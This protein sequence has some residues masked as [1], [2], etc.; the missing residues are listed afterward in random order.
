MWG[1]QDATEHPERFVSCGLW[2]LL[3]YQPG[4]RLVYGRNPHFWMVDRLG[5]R[6]PYLH[7]YVVT[8]AKDL[9]NLALQ[10]EQGRVESYGVP[11]SNLRHVRHLQRPAFNL[12]NLG[13]TSTT[14]FLAFNLTQA[15]TA[16]KPRVSPVR[17]AWFRS[18]R[19]RQAVAYAIRRDVLVQNVLRGVGE[20]LFTAEG[21]PSLYLHPR[22]AQG[23]AHNLA[24]AR[25]LLREDGFGWDARGRLLD[26]HGNPVVFDMFTN[27]GNDQREATGVSL[28]Q[29]L[30]ELGIAVHFKP[31]DFNV[32]V[33][34]LSSGQWETMVMGLTGSALEP[35]DGANVWKSQGALHLFNQ[36]DVKALAGKTPTDRLPWEQELDAVFEAGAQTLL[37]EKR[38]PYYLRYQEIVAEQ[39]P[40][41]YLFSPLS[42]VAIRSHLRN[43]APTTLGVWHNLE[44]VWIAPET[45]PAARR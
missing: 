23:Y 2:V 14:T 13:P 25:A 32:L 11:G 28:Q 20:A 19:F 5:R 44:E 38:R 42:V 30:A 21:L 12:Y 16:G 8:F 33:G 1:V 36:R 39:N 9:N 37:P 4:E 3:S 22:L 34:K 43:V 41:I 6:L 7:R 26:R 29:D 24:Q 10:F 27:T 40:L 15:H 35:H 18:K 45:A 17:S 31:L